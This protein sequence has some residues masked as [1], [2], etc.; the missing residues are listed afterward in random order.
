MNF[1]ASILWC[2]YLTISLGYM[3]RHGIAGSNGILMLNLI[4][5]LPPEKLYQ[6]KVH[7]LELSGKKS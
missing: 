5:H 2:T 6:F 4:S 3:S 1:I 7:K